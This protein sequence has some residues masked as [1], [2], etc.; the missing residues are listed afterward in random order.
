MGMPDKPMGGTELM[1][2]ELMRRLSDSYKEHFSIFNYVNQAD[3]SKTTVYWNQLSYDQ[4]AV[5]FL[6]DP[7]YVEKIDWFV[8]VSHWQAEMYRK[9]FRIPGYK[10]RVIPNGC[11]GVEQRK[12]GPRTKV[13][14]C[15][16]STPWRGLEVLLKAWEIL[17]PVDCEL[18][19]F[20]S[21]R[22][23]GTDFAKND[24]QYEHLYDKC[25]KLP[26][27][28]Y[29]GSIPND[30]LRA[31]LPSF[32]ILAY[33]CTFEETSCIAVIE[34]LSAGLRV[35][36]SSIGALP[37]TTCSWAKMYSFLENN[38]LHAEKFA[39]VLSEEIEFIKR[40]KLDAFLEGQTNFYRNFYSWDNVQNLWKNTLT[41]FII[42]KIGITCRNTW[43]SH[44]FRECYVDNEYELE[45]LSPE[46]VVIDLGV[47]IGSFSMLAHHKGSRNIHGYEVSES[48]YS[49]ALK[50]TALLPGINLYKKAVWRSDDDR[51]TVNFDTNIVDWNTGMGIIGDS[52]KTESVE[53]ECVKFDD[54]LS[55]FHSVR[56]LK[57]DVEGSEYPILY[58][59]KQLYKIKEISGEYHNL[60]GNID[61]YGYNGQ[62]LSRFLEDQGFTVTKLERAYWS[63]DCG[64]F[65][66]T[67]TN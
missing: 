62:E 15:Y 23:Y 3:F 21:C 17:K 61:G 4:E 25:N 59:S 46:D 33:P 24:T 18:H 45:T 31:E 65:K 51:K 16:T 42:S 52:V 14:L 64:F 2:E 56:F 37:E 54:V 27:V 41:R 1:Y 13:R 60:E 22:I 11:I 34:A 44:I 28:V 40:G 8:F 29:R 5:Q 20:S 66:A 53:V 32:D 10:T 38:E 30:E 43:E 48:N 36:T 6:K 47:H 35:V 55:K 19:V 49:L 39:E 67:R 50:N 26:G 7:K 57:I 9:T 12:P 58:T 63:N